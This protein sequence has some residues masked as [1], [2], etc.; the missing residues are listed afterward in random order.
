MFSADDLTLTLHAVREPD[1]ERLAHGP[2]RRAAT[3]TLELDAEGRAGARRGA[4]V[5]RRRAAAR[6]PG[7]RGP[8]A[9]RR[10]RRSSGAPGSASRRTPGRWRE[11]RAALGDHAEADDLRADRRRWWRRRRPGLPEQV[12]GE[13]NWDY[14]YT[15]VRDASFSVYAL[16]GL[17]F[18]EEAAAFGGW[19]RRP[20]RRSRSAATARPAEHHVPGRRLLRPEGGVAGALGGLP[21][22]APGAHRQRRRRPAAARHLR[23]GDGQHLLRRPARHPSSAT[24]AG[25]R[26]RDM[27]DW[28]ADNWDQPEEGIWETRGGRQDFTYGRLMC[29]VAFDRGI[30][31]ATAHGRPGAARALDRERGRASTSRSWTRGWNAER[32]AFVQHYGSDVLDSSLLRM[33]TV[34]FIAPDDPMWTSTLRRDGRGAGHRQ[35]GLPLRPGGL[36]RR[37]ARLRGH[38]LAVHVLVRRRARPRRPARRGAARR[39]RRC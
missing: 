6:D 16:L 12:G 10:H 2:R 21:R 15:W 33:P 34:G 22:L 27:L 36:T 19:L 20:G 14:R 11:T 28:L 26:I 3:C 31:L 32:Q 38:V 9:V 25:L 17:G 8:A 4:G 13:R 39:S 30:R 5:G 29:W 1:D 7:R 23:R 35:P 37:A 18:T 24:G